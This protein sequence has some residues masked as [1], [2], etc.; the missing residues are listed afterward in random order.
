MAR[1]LRVE[2]PGAYYHV[3]SRGIARDPILSGDAHKR[4]F[5]GILRTVVERYRLKVH[6]Y[7]VM[8]NHY[9][10]L[11][12]TPEGNL[13]LAMRQL[14]GVYG[15]KYNRL[16]KRPGPVF[17][18]RFKACVV[19]ADAY[20]LTLCRYIVLNPVRA[21]IVRK[22]EQWRWS[23]HRAM[24]GLAPV[25]AWLTTD[26]VLGRLGTGKGRAARRRYRE[27]IEEGREERGR[28]V[29]RMM[30][31]VVLGTAEFKQTLVELLAE[32][33]DEQEV[34]KSQRYEGRPE[35]ATLFTQPMKKK[36]RDRQIVDA[37]LKHGY[38][39]KAIADALG[40]HYATISRIV[41]NAG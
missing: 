41:N 20:L 7:C 26:F 31:Q 14:H 21:R 28:D 38:T 19:E 10:L 23:S 1:P 37:H 17:Q 25:P 6:C 3:Y 8:S 22:A 18:G 27:F 24:A 16:L 12:E 36:A 9:H 5:L 13:S 29:E 34:P 15:Q 35:L 32:K 2:Y 30:R 33:R 4:L 39:Q 40:M 11:L